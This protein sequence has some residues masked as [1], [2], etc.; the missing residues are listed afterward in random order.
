MQ[1]SD[2]LMKGN[3]IGINWICYGSTQELINQDAITIKRGF[4]VNPRAT[5]KGNY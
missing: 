4:Q 1:L 3:S 2:G 5:Y